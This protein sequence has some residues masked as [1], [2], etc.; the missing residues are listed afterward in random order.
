[1]S[2]FVVRARMG[3]APEIRRNPK[4]YS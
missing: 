4:K 1:M 2:L 3:T